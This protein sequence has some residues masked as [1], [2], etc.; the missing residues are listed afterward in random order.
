[1]KTF[2][3]KEQLTNYLNS[4]KRSK[5]KIGLVPTMGALHGGHLS[6]IAASKRKCDLTVATIF[7]NPTQFNNADDLLKYPK[8]IENDKILLVNAGCDV[9]FNPEIEEMYEPNEKWDYKV[10]DLNR[11]LEGKFRPGHYEGVTQIVYKLFKLVKPDFAFFGQKDYQQ[12]LVITKMAKDFGLE[13]ELEAC[14]IVRE[15]DGL[16]MSSRNI[17]LNADER[18]KSLQLYKSLSFI[19]ENYGQTPNNEL[20][21]QA[22][23]FYNDD[24]LHLEYLEIVDLKNLQPL[25]N[26]RNA[27]ALVACSVGNTRLIDNM[28]LP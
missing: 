1:M 20:L 7:V 23:D 2:T 25:T 26:Q 27:I 6:L 28:M 17:R 8:P 9:L 15:K 3:T 24:L 16:A 19:K 18:K 12:F 4:V 22:K 5:V 14:P 13:I 11:V 21:K 10:G